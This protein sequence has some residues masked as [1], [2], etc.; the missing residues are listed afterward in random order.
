MA[1]G[2]GC[3][4][5]RT[6]RS[7][8]PEEE[9][10]RKEI[11]LPF[12]AAFG[13]ACFMVWIATIPAAVSYLFGRGDATVWHFINMASLAFGYVAYHGPVAY[14]LLT[15]SLP[16]RLL[17]VAF[18]MIFICILIGDV[19]CLVFE[20]KTQMWPLVVLVLDTQLVVGVPTWESLAVLT[21]TT[22]WLLF[23]TGYTSKTLDQPLTLP[24]LIGILFFWFLSVCIVILDFWFTRGFASALRVQRQELE[25]SIEASEEIAVALAQYKMHDAACVVRGTRGEGLPPRLRGAFEHL[26]ANLTLYRCYLPQSALPVDEYDYDSECSSSELYTDHAEYTENEESVYRNASSFHTLAGIAQCKSRNVQ[27][28]TS[29]RSP[30]SIRSPKSEYTSG[31]SPRMS[32]P[33]VET[34][35]STGSRHRP[36]TPN[37]EV[38]QS[39]IMSLASITGLRRKASVKSEVA[40]PIPQSPVPETLATLSPKGRLASPRDE[41]LASQS[42]RAKMTRPP[43]L[44]E[45]P[46]AALAVGLDQRSV[47]LVH[48][49]VVRYHARFSSCGG[50]APPK[51]TELA[52]LQMNFHKI[53]IEV[54][55]TAA[56]PRGTVDLLTG[57]RGRFAFNASRACGNHRGLATQAALHTSTVRGADGLCVSRAVMRLAAFVASF[58]AESL[59]LSVGCTSGTA[60][61]G[62]LGSRALRSFNLLG[63]VCNWACALERLSA[64][65]VGRCIGDGAIAEG[66]RAILRAIPL[67]V[68]HCKHDPGGSKRIW[69]IEG[70]GEQANYNDVN[71]SASLDHPLCQ[72]GFSKVALANPFTLFNQAVDAYIAGEWDAAKAYLPALP[73]VLAEQL[74]PKIMT[75]V[76]SDAGPP[77]PLILYDAAKLP[78]SESQDTEQ[79]TS[80][81]GAASV[82]TEYKVAEG[83]MRHLRDQEKAQQLRHINDK[84]R[85]KRKQHGV[86]TAEGCLSSP[87]SSSSPRS[88]SGKGT[89]KSVSP[90]NRSNSNRAFDTSHERRLSGREAKTNDKPET[91]SDLAN[92]PTLVCESPMEDVVAS[93]PLA[94]MD[95]M[96]ALMNS[97]SGDSQQTQKQD[98]N[99]DQPKP[100]GVARP[101]QVEEKF[102]VGTW[103]QTLG[104][105][106]YVDAFRSNDVCMK[107]LVGALSHDDLKSMGIASLSHRKRVMGA[108]ELLQCHVRPSASMRPV[109][110]LSGNIRE[111]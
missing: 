11:W 64:Q 101:S 88:L 19:Q 65:G 93:G 63:T 32:E 54:L 62:N 94:L 38:F 4:V 41:T 12:A 111:L 8:E 102:D 47:S 27:P 68:Q 34:G 75:A 16:V 60:M 46:T 15:Q 80:V 1:F 67:P 21:G 69:S 49:N 43:G 17:S 39:K 89:P 57:D 30:R 82:V 45:H 84:V 108:A 107:D 26:I 104:L 70:M 106:Q 20:S 90:Q 59:E 98:G 18:L 73:R 103:L 53:F 100:E 36:P 91:K 25:S 66:S 6:L 35:V 105:N 51:S 79:W 3:V 92:E 77:Q 42:P 85:E 95:K 71:A 87:K 31:S 61:V 37:F 52:N 13:C 5:R 97:R 9:R 110:R 86:P 78:T 14:A 10:L 40:S 72:R 48:V 23:R 99:S 7:G 109:A 50:K 22:M 81:P 2:C 28:R 29:P 56:Q 83:H 24:L 76:S 58:D 44:A 74:W 33:R 96:D 55:L